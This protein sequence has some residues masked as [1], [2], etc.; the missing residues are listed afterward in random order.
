MAKGSRPPATY[1]TIARSLRS[2]RADAWTSAQ[3]WVL[4]RV[5][6]MLCDDL[7]DLNPRFDSERFKTMAGYAIGTVFPDQRE[8]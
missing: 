6:E 7:W 2:A 5:I 4:D 8:R 3:L 1:S